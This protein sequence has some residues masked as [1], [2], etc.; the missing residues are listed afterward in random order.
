MY[1][2]TLPSETEMLAN[3][4][5]FCADDFEDGRG[6]GGLSARICPRW[7]PR[8]E[9]SS[10]LLTPLI[11]WHVQCY[12]IAQIQRIAGGGASKRSLALATIRTL[13]SCVAAVVDLI[14]RQQS[15]NFRWCGNL[16]LV[17]LSSAGDCGLG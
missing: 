11:K 14:L 10:K 17:S 15:R 9:C 8:L 12:K 3:C 2:R 13:G 6:S 16:K 5:G 1:D 4:N 7:A